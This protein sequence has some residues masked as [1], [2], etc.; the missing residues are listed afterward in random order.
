MLE[1][2]THMTDHSSIIENRKENTQ[3]VKNRAVIKITVGYPEYW[4]IWLPFKQFWI[5]LSKGKSQWCY[6][7]SCRIHFKCSVNTLWKVCMFV[8]MFSFQNK[9]IGK[10]ITKMERND[11]Q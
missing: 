11:L 7:K 1:K 8:S 10:K 3:T 9:Q 4:M 5:I 2:I 6:D